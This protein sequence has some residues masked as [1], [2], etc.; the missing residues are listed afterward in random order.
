MTQKYRNIRPVEKSQW[1][2]LYIETYGCQMNINDSEV[3][4]AVMQDSG[5][6]LCHTIDLADVI[7]IN[8]C[9]IR[10]NAEQRVL[11]R[12]DLFRQQK[13]KKPSLK[14]GVLGCMAGR[15]KEELLNHPAVDLVVGPDAYRQLPKLLGMASQG[16]KPIDIGLNPKETYADL[17]PVRLDPNGVSAFV[18]IMRGCNNACAYC[19]VPFVRGRERSRDPQTIEREVRE[20]VA[21]GYKEVTLLGQNVDSYLWSNPQNP[22]DCLNFSQLLEI[23]ALVDP[24]LRVRFVT[25]HPKDM[26][27]GVLYTM[28]MYPNI[29]NHIHLP[30]QS[31]SNQILHKMNR[32][33]TREE[34]LEHI[35]SIRQIL[36][37]C[38]VSSDFIAGFCDETDQDHAD[39]LSLMN[40]VQFDQAFMF[41]YSER[42][43]TKAAN[44]YH[45]NVAENI[46]TQR[47]NEIIAL[48]NKHALASNQRDTG[49]T[50]EVLVEGVSKRSN[51]EYYGRT[52]QNKVCVFPK[53]TCTIGAY[54]QVKILRCTSAT[55]LGVIT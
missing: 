49:K 2:Q 34:Y 29:C 43:G 37:D 17:S 3:V 38:A 46:K 33:Y 1:P 5:Y 21:N 20:V 23:V 40:Q 13:K 7:L 15:L 22:T 41:Q 28:A 52:P 30:V 51:L 44:M 9:S 36:P 35:V 24:T 31:G 45:D 16:N 14:V 32:R 11:G 19:V 50:F 53:A 12:L 47:L 6:S 25:S 26:G 39:T 48:Q 4:L 54:V 42:S 10:D 18:S 8:T 27:K 55:L